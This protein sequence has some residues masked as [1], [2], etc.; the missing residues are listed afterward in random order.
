MYSRND[1]LS[2]VVNTM[3][4]ITGE[5]TMGCRIIKEPPLPKVRHNA[6]PPRPW[7]RWKAFASTLKAGDRLEPMPKKDALSLMRAMYRMDP[8]MEYTRRDCKDGRWEIHIL[9]GC[10]EVGK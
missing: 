9:K 5:N 1:A 10:N 7:G 8:P 2:I 4:A 6:V 3:C